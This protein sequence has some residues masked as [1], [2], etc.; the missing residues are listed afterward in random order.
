MALSAERNRRLFQETLLLRG[1]GAVTVQAP[2]LSNRRQMET[3]FGEHIVDDGA[4]A[5]PA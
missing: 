3:V 1:V 2:I 5:S 4:V